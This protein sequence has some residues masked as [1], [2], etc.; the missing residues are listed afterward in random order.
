MTRQR[1]L[2]D[3][4]RQWEEVEHELFQLARR[5]AEMTPEEYNVQRLRLV[6][7][8]DVLELQMAELQRDGDAGS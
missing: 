1:K 4:R 8:R 7:L 6:Q 3:A 2:S 5:K